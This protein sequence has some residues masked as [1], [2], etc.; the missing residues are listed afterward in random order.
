[1]LYQGTE[2][3]V[4]VFEAINKVKEQVNK[5]FLSLKKFLFPFLQPLTKQ[6]NKKQMPYQGTEGTVLVFETITKVKEQET[7][8]LLSLRRFWFRI[9]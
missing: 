5:T 4:L 2:G 6:K 7:K 3:T 8:F 1:M 9:L